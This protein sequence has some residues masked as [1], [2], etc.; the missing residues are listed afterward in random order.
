MRGDQWPGSHKTQSRAGQRF[1][2]RERGKR[3]RCGEPEKTNQPPEPDKERRAF[4][5]AHAPRSRVA[6]FVEI[7]FFFG[8]RAD[9]QH[10][11]ASLSFETHHALGVSRSPTLREKQMINNVSTDIFK[12]QKCGE[13]RG[14]RAKMTVRPAKELRFLH[15]KST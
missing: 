4:K 3:A 7:N 13:K 8:P 1:W 14:R 15:V 9:A 5:H 2:K 6:K 11:N 10:P 12:A